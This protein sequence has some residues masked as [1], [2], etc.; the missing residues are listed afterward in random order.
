MTSD[1]TRPV[2]SL[3]AVGVI[4]NDLPPHRAPPRSRSER[5]VIEVFPEYA[6]GL[7]DIETCTHLQIVFCFDKAPDGAAP[8]RQHPQGDRA[9]PLRGVFA[10]RSPRRPNPIGLT[11]VELLEVRG[12]ELVVGGLDAWDD[13]PVL[14][15]KPHVPA[16][17]D[18]CL[19]EGADP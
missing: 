17:G 5:S 15:I 2:I 1:E 7:L 4:H 6:A 16:L 9:K 19:S 10:L 18:G 13:T 11:T 8:L 14:D 3:R 12:C